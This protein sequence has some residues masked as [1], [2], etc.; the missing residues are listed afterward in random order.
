MKA[1]GQ[2]ATGP[3]GLA[4]FEQYGCGGCHTLKSAPGANG[5]VGPDLDKLKQEAAQANQPLAS[6]IRASIIRPH[7]YIAP[8]Y[9][10]AMPPNFGTVIPA[11]QLDELVQYLEQSAK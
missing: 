9:P 2:E 4:V 6:F 7:A 1:G 10:D 3:P 11:P 8:G 5:T